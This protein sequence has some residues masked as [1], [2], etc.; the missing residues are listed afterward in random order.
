MY[1]ENPPIEPH[2]QTDLPVEIAIRPVEPTDVNFVL[3]SWLQSYRDSLRSISNYTYYPEQQRLIGALADRAKLVVACDAE[4]PSF[5]LGWACGEPLEVDGGL[6]LHY[7]YVK[8]GYR[9]LHIGQD[10][11]RALGWRAG[12]EITA[13]H[14]NRAAT[15]LAAKFKVRHNPYY[16]MIGH[17]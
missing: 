17:K 3:N 11:L 16:L 10:M 1:Y 13:T 14:W 6:L 7:I 5:I 15:S 8:Q 4:T 12:Q 2:P 9:S